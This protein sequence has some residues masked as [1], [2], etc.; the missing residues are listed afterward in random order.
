MHEYLRAVGFSDIKEKEELKHLLQMTEESYQCER[1]S[2][3]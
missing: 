1:T 3:I 2:G